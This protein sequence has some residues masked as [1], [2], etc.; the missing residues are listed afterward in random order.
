VQKW[1]EELKF[2]AGEDIVVILVGNKTDLVEEK[3]STRQVTAADAAKFAKENG[4][5]FKESSVFKNINVTETFEAL[6]KG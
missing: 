6:L 4:M 3:P 1:Y 5:I 2:H